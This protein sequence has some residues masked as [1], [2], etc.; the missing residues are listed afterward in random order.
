ML[1]HA[2]YEPGIDGFHAKNP[3]SLLLHAADLDAA[4]FRTVTFIGTG[5]FTRKAPHR[6]YHAAMIGIVI[7]AAHHIRFMVIFIF[8]GHIHMGQA[9]FKKLRFIGSFGTA[10]VGMTAPSDKNAGEI[11]QIV[12]V[13]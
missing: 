1:H 5:R 2:L 3:L 6:R 4:P 8:Q 11:I 13:S 12:P 9:L 10:A 7:I